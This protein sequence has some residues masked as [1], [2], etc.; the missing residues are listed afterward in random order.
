MTSFGCK[1]NVAILLTFNSYES[2]IPKLGWCSGA[3]LGYR[4]V[5]DLQDIPR[6]W[7]LGS[8]FMWKSWWFTR[9]CS[10]HLIIYN[11]LQRSKSSVPNWFSTLPTGEPPEISRSIHL[12][13]MI[14]T[15]HWSTGLYPRAQGHAAG[16]STSSKGARW[17][18]A[19]A[20]SEAKGLLK[21][22]GA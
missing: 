20:A 4:R 2:F 3:R 8:I 10:W 22:L 7:H 12:A 9:I 1:A 6:F 15:T 13:L 11:D 14:G 21:S 16:D 18:A 19:H 17:I 5:S